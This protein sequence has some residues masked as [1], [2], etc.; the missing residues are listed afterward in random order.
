MLNF[1]NPHNSGGGVKHGA[2]AQEECLDRCS[3]LYDSISSLKMLHEYYEYNRSIKGYLFSDR[4]IY[5]PDV[6]VFKDDMT[7]DRLD[8]SF[9]VDVITCA[10]PYN[11]Y[12]HDEDLLKKVFINRIT[13]I[14]EAAID[15]EVDMIIL[16]AFGCGVFRNPP[17]LVADSFNQII[18]DKYRYKFRKISFAI[19]KGSIFDNNLETFKN[20][21]NVI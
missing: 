1:A 11:V 3:N 12:G 7:Y 10:A 5:S 16:G 21:I 20:V 13:N 2:R 18:R 17:V 19:K 8:E 6:T 15:N 9:K 14:F 4:I